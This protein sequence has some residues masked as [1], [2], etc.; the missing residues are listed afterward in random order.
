MNPV[1]VFIIGLA[2]FAYVGFGLVLSLG[3]HA[4]PGEHDDEPDA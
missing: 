2:L 1:A 3:A 4:M